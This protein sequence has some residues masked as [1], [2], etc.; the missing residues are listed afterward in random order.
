MPLAGSR[1]RPSCKQQSTVCSSCTHAACMDASTCAKSNTLFRVHARNCLN[2]LQVPRTCKQCCSTVAS[3]AIGLDISAADGKHT[4]S[5]RCPTAAR[6][7]WIP[8]CLLTQQ[9]QPSQQQCLPGSLSCGVVRAGPC[10]LCP[11]APS[12]VLG[13][14]APRSC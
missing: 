3:S 1:L 12:A 9:N 7:H 11:A 4:S 6:Q 8:H 10:P 13:C 2:R 5:T 14:T